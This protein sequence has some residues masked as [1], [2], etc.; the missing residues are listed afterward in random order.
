[1]HGSTTAQIAAQVGGLLNGTTAGTVTLAS[2]TSA[3]SANKPLSL[4]VQVDPATVT[5][6]KLKDM[7]V[8]TTNPVALS[9]VATIKEVPGAVS[10]S[11][12]NGDQ[13]ASITG[14]ITS[15]DTVNVQANVEKEV[16]KLSLPAGVTVGSGTQA[17]SQTEALQGLGIA[18]LIAIGLVYLV[19]LIWSGSLLNPLVILFSL[20]LAA[21]GAILGLFITGSPLASLP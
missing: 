16:K 3:T 18:L 17:Q 21:I 4:F 6:Q 13:A 5:Q 1:M 7:L 15:Q 10:V 20:P 14:K 12:I 11:R 2:G 9:E 8:G 19:M